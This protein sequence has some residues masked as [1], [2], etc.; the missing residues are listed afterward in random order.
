[1]ALRLRRLPLAVAESLSA[2][3]H[4]GCN[5]QSACDRIKQAEKQYIDAFNDELESFK[6][7]VKE[8]AE[9]RLENARKE[10]EEE[11]RQQRL[12]PG[13]LDPVEVMESLPKVSESKYALSIA[14]KIKF[15]TVL[16]GKFTRFSV[17]G[18]TACKC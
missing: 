4:T 12:G 7:R 17:H 9:I 1:M 3:L 18:L 5:W 14:S 11:E 8:R 2:S 13:G 16:R 6:L 15:G 10:L